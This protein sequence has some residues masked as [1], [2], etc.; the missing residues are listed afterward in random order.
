MKKRIFLA[1]LAF[2]ALFVFVDTAGAVWIWTPKTKKWENPKYATKDTPKLQFEFAMSYFNAGDYKNTQK[3]FKKLLKAYPNSEFAPEAQF[4]L[5]ASHQKLEEY[6]GAF[7]AYQKVI[8]TYPYS[9]RVDQIIAEQFAV[10]KIFYEGYKSKI[11]G[12][13]I[14]PSTD[15]AIEVFSKVVENSPYGKYAPE[16]QYYLGLSYKKMAQYKEAIEAFQKVLDE[17]PQSPLAEDAKFQMGQCYAQAAPKSGYDQVNT[18][19]SIS[20]FKELLQTSPGGKKAKEASVFLDQLKEKK[21]ESVFAT[22]KFYERLKKYSSAEVYYKQILD[23]YPKT[24]WA[25]KALERL[26]ILKNKGKI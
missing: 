15:K 5:G 1:A 18:E 22:A 8:E 7:L 2:V 9:E 14:L 6:Y 17:Y 20:E 21:A 16:A 19:E 3:E 10:G 25:A 23:E 4:Y 26:E 13:A 24:S 12:M 11:L